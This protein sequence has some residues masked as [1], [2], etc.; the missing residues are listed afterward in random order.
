[1]TGQAVARV[2]VLSAVVA[3]SACVGERERL[4][5]PRLTLELADS[6]AQ[7]HAPIFGRVRAVDQSGVIFLGVY[8][9]TR[10]S[11]FRQRQD[12]I[13]TDSAEFDFDLH[14]AA[15]TPPNAPIRVLAVTID[16]QDFTVDTSQVIYLRTGEPP[17]GPPDPG[18]GLCNTSAARQQ[19]R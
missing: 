17:S 2:A 9:C 8:A 10:D 15:N 18:E 16:N 4:D 12:Y 13:R 6:V 1:M 3:A 19:A 7:P 5:V 14:F 11:I